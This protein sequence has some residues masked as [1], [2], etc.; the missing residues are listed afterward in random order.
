[1]T[2]R[3]STTQV[4][5]LALLIA[6]NVTIARVFLIPVPMTRGNINLCD[7][8]I[9]IAAMLYGRKQG[10]IVGGLSGLLLDLISGYAQY[11]I[12]SLIVHG[13]E[14]YIAGFL[15]EKGKNSRAARFTGMGIGVIV[16]VIGYAITDTILYNWSAGFLSIPM[17]VIQGIA[18]GLVAYPLFVSIR[19][20]APRLSH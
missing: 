3:L 13:L 12:F 17:N 6:L 11:M 16:M 5:Y 19:K 2:K 14:G 7:A 4:V 18:G 20:F 8:G 1:M 10:A 9:F 15:A